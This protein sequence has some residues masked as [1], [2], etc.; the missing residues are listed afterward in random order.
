MNINMKIVN[1]R[2][3][4]GIKIRVIGSAVRVGVMVMVS[5]R[6]YAMILFW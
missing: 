3:G 2:H 1:Y 6:V 5:L 4:S